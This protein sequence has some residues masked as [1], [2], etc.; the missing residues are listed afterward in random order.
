[1]RIKAMKIMGKPIE[2]KEMADPTSVATI[3]RDYKA[4][5]NG[6]NSRT[7]ISALVTPLLDGGSNNM[8]V[9]MPSV[10]S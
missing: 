4:G 8:V 7:H 2:A 10:T 9:Q 6:T 1:M 3:T 5:S